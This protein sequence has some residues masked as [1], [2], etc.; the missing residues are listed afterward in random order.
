MDLFIQTGAL[1]L[2]VWYTLQNNKDWRN[3]LAERNSKLEKALDK[4]GSI[5]D[6]HN[7]HG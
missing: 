4:L 6:K 1:G 2:F 5:L 7:H 3:H